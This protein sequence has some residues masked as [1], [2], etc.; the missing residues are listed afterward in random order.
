MRFFPDG[1]IIMMTT[2]EEPQTFVPRLRSTNARYAIVLTIQEG[3]NCRDKNL[4]HF[5]FQYMNCIYLQV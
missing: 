3:L 5:F 1:Q 4:D 2:P